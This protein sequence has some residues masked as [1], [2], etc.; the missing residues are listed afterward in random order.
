M[1]SKPGTDERYR[2]CVTALRS[3]G[4]DHILRW[5]SELS[6]VQRNRLLDE[7][8]AIPWDQIEPRIRSH[9]L[10]RPAYHS[11]TDLE[12]AEVFPITPDAR[13]EELYGDAR[14]IGRGIIS[15]GSVAAFTVAGGQG[16][17]LGVRGPKGCVEVTPVASKSLFQLFAEMI[18]AVR[19]RFGAPIPWYIMTNVEN[20]DRTISFFGE[21]GYFGLRREDVMMF[22]QG[23]LPAFDFNGRLLLAAKDRL[24]L[25]PD[26]HG[27]SLRALVRSGALEDMRRRGVCVISY[28]QVDNPLVNPFDPLFVGLH[29]FTGSDMSTKVAKKINDFEKVGNVCRQNDRTV[30]IEYTE[31]P[32]KAA[33]SRNP[34]GSRRFDAANLAIHLLNIDFV[35]RVVAQSDLPFR[36]AEKIVPYVGEDGLII[37]PTSPKAVKL[38]T[39]VFDFLPLAN[40]PLVLEVDRSEEFSPV[41]N[42]TGV[43]SLESAKR[44][45]VRRA[46]RWLEAAGVKIPR[47]RNGEPDVTVEISPF[48]AIEAG[49]VAGKADRILPLKPSTTIYIE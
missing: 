41:K 38:E 49:D 29:G 16:T 43:D 42:L 10:E 11:V 5:W 12:P 30:V 17:R 44:D 28:F 48:F 15:A 36:R 8:D 47:D 37:K 7:I 9:V 31:F 24:A 2:N 19:K 4:Q 21:H 32:E 40:N 3:R 34:D 45:Q 39:F 1:T 26:G 46:C 27:G 14:A 23:M 6:E 25:A 35:E 20:H 13:R 22:P 18:L 33:Q